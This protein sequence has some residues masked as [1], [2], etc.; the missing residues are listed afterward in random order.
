MSGLPVSNSKVESYWG[1]PLSNTDV[2]ITE[3]NHFPAYTHTCTRTHV[4]TCANKRTYTHSLHT[5]I[6][7]IPYQEMLLYSEVEL[8]LEIIHRQRQ[9]KLGGYERQENSERWN[10]R[11][12]GRQNGQFIFLVKGS[13]WDVCNRVIVV[14][15]HLVHYLIY[16]HERIFIS[17]NLAIIM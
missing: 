16:W 11:D 5:W 14:L 10:Y 6:L 1:K 7:R 3:E 15:V 13:P 17:D 9:L 12:H 8:A 4:Q 2:N